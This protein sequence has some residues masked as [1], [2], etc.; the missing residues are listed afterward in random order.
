MTSDARILRP[1]NHQENDIFKELH[2]EHV[3]TFCQKCYFSFLHASNGFW[4]GEGGSFE[5]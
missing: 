3:G 1:L 2:M 4:A 5:S